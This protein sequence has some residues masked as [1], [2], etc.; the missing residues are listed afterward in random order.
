MTKKIRFFLDSG[1]NIHS[2]RTT[3]KT[4]EELG[5]TDEEWDNMPEKEKEEMAR[6]IAWEAMDWGF[7]EVE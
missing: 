7:G 4:T 1:A 3:I 5:L 2:C 6:E